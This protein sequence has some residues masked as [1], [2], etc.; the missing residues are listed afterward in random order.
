MAITQD[1]PA[2]AGTR[3]LTVIVLAAGSLV[4][5]AANT[6]IAFSALAA[7]ASATFSPLLPP[8]YGVF[9]VLGVV[10]AYF[11]WN[12][13]RR[14]AKNPAATLR[15]LVP[16]L[17]VLSYVPDVILLVTGFIP[18]SSLTAVVALALMHLVVVGV[19]VPVAQRL[20]PVGR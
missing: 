10:A 9:S 18:G 7:G 14:R 16:L 2:V 3:R 5:I 12:I 1:L 8:V 6:V 20:S 11:G 19:A 13:V 17:V 4:A 15:V